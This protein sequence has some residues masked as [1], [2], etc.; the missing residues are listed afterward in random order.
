MVIAI[1]FG[2][3]HPRVPGQGWS[4]YAQ[5]RVHY[6]I[7]GYDGG[8]LYYF[9]YLLSPR[10]YHCLVSWSYRL[11]RRRLH[12]TQSK[13]LTHLSLFTFHLSPFTFHLSVFTFHLSLFTFHL[14]PFT[15]HL[16]LFTFHFSPFTELPFHLVKAFSDCIFVTFFSH[17]Q[18]ASIAVVLGFHLPSNQFVNLYKIFSHLFE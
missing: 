12:R 10:S 2:Q 5:A 3:I 13:R 11:P 9:L 18:T 1:I 17:I 4:H 14:S 6:R 16:S 15:F 8:Y 7:D